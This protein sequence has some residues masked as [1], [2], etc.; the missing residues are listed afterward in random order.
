MNT[1][2]TIQSIEA[3][4]VD[5]PTI[6]AHKL[7]M[8]TLTRQTLVIVRLACSDGLTGLGEATT[9]GGLAY[10]DQSPESIK[11]A[12]D[13]LDIQPDEFWAGVDWLSR[14]ASSGERVAVRDPDDDA[15]QGSG[16]WHAS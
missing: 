6:R 13:D 9:I 1:S 12:I 8:T 7:A 10:G 4:L 5:L 14:L 2:P 11:S 15:E 16:D 3:I